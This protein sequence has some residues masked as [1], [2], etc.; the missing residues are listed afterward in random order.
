MSLHVSYVASVSFG[1]WH[2]FRYLAAH[3]HKQGWDADRCPKNS[4][5]FIEQ[6]HLK[7]HPKVQRNLIHCWF[8][9]PRR[10]IKYFIVVEFSKHL[11]IQICT[12]FRYSAIRGASKNSKNQQ[13]FQV[14]FKLCLS[15]KTHW[16]KGFFKNLGFV[17]LDYTSL[18]FVFSGC[19]FNNSVW[20]LW[21][22]CW[23]IVKPSS[24][25]D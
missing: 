14:R 21:W 11:N 25:F 2:V 20:K 18:L 22:N 12:Y 7:N 1:L 6:F 23:M 24:R 19:L 15:K 5:D 10:K 9:V 8:L 4:M 17:N 16:D 13:I 3:Q